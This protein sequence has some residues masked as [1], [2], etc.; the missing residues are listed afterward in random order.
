MR[1][2]KKVATTATL[3]F[4]A[5]PNPVQPSEFEEKA[6][7]CSNKSSPFSLILL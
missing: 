3:I 1:I 5:I 2:Y 6:L 4:Y 7:G